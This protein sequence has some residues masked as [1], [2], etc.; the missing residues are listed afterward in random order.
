MIKLSH[1]HEFSCVVFLIVRTVYSVDDEEEEEED[2]VYMYSSPPKSAPGK[3]NQINGGGV[4]VSDVMLMTRV[5][6]INV[7]I[8]V[9]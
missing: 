5:M 4:R 8:I 1:T 6:I 9:K 3:D 2:H 7:I